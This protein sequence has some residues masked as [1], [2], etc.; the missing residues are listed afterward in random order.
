MAVT[1]DNP[2]TLLLVWAALDITELITQ[3][4]FADSP[5]NNEKV[6]TSFSTRALGI[7]LLLWANIVSVAREV[8]LTFNPLHQVQVCFL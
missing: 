3:L 4:V 2:L 7:G 6:V 5:A 1:A 8:V